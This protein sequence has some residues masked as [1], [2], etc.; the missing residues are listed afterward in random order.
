M[1]KTKVLI[2]GGG[3]AGS[4][5]LNQV[6]K[7][8]K[9]KSDIEISLVSDDNFFLFTPMLPEVSSG[10]LHPSD[11]S[12]PIRT[13]CKNA[14]FYHA[15]MSHIDLE[16][17]KVA[18]T[19]IFDQKLILLHYDYLVL[20]LGSTDNFFGNKN[21]E[22][23]SFT[24]KTLEDAIAIRNHVI[25][26]LESADNE[27]DK[28][29]QDELMNFVVVG[30]GFAGVEIAAEIN[31]FILDAAKNFYKNIDREKIR[32]ILVSARNGILPEV[33]ENLGQ[34]ALKFLK[35]SG[36]QVITNRKAVNAG[37][38]HVLLDNNTTIP[39]TTLVWAGGMVVDP[40]VSSLDCLHDS[41][42]RI[43]VDEFLRV[44]DHPNVFAVGDC[45]YVTDKTT[46][47]PYPTTAQIA[48]REA[49]I[50]SHNLI[51]IVK[52]S[53]KQMKPLE[54]KN[55]GVMATIGKRTGVSLINGI[56]L[57]GFSAWLIWRLFYWN[58]LPTREKKIRVAFDWMLDLLF[59]GDIMTV[60][61]IKKKTLS[62]LEPSISI[63]RQNYQSSSNVDA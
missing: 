21:I 59:R 10:M 16:K 29:V 51:S 11:V 43:M 18:I 32:V 39:C 34:Y 53:N 62:K 22:K 15:K 27:D 2:L 12:T 33:G 4:R 3:F 7:K 19:R 41:S 13:F 9:A 30:G 52:K 44:K 1:Q 54:Y 57:R 28:D 46:G 35:K 61:V 40:V 14:K 25:S 24:I 8:F 38:D 31:D 17:R 47:K 58:N 49:K 20:A 23:Y 26:M 63:N 48:I 37:E 45:A 56:P 50:A 60:G 55:K 6:Q 5:I 42:G 36:I